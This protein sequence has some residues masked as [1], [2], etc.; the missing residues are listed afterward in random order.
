[1]DVMRIPRITTIVGTRPEII[2]LSCILE[3]FEVCF[4]HRLIHT[5]QNSDPMLSQVFINDL[6]IRKPDVYLDITNKSLGNFCAQLFIEIENEFDHFPPDAVVILGDT[7]S[8][9]A[10]IIAKRKGIPV[11]HLEAGNRSFDVNVPEETNRKIVD[12]FSDYNLAYTQNAKQNLIIEGL[13]VN[14]L[15]VIGSPLREVLDKYRHKI[16]S[17]LVLENLDLTT[18]SYFLVSAHRQENIDLYNR[19]G[20]LIESINWIATEFKMPVVVST[21]P[22]MRDKLE[23]HESKLQSNVLLHEPF[24]FF[25]YNKLQMNAKIVLSDSGSVPEEAAI[26]GFPAITIRDSMERPE[27][28]ESGSVIMSGISKDGISEAI[29]ILSS[30]P[31]EVSVPIDYQVTDTSSR[32][33]KFIAS[34]LYT[35]NFRVGRRN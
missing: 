29:R 19:L 3:K 14:S 7:N 27:A 17:S 24:G 2:R 33:V 4:Q 1:M 26:L 8:A 15:T 5:G 13:L 11:Y 10:G 16:E 22:R 9:L 23:K 18:N 34:T 12:H 21:H 32:V 31:Q 25:D 28:L 35:H 30:L 20:T 6:G